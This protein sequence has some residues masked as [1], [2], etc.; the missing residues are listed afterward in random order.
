[1]A[2]IDVMLL[3]N[4]VQSIDTQIYSFQLFFFFQMH[5]ASHVL[6]TAPMGFDLNL[7]Q[8]VLN[9]KTTSMS[10]LSLGLLG[11]SQSLNLVVDFV[12]VS[13]CQANL[14][15]CLVQTRT[16]SSLRQSC[17]PDVL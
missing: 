5:A 15:N 12:S 13:C 3:E 7:T 11:S 14:P 9:V 1:M 4:L 10:L 8:Q 2:I 6:R 17:Q 16:Y